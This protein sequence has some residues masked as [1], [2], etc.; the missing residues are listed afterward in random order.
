MASHKDILG[1]ELAVGDVVALAA[2][3]SMAIAIIDK[4]NPKMVR[5]KRPNSN[6][7]QNKYSQ[8][9]IKIDGT[10]AMIY[11]LKL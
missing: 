3:N 8:D 5:V 2:Y 1:R 7:T 6:W 9:L 10:D 11:L 4:L